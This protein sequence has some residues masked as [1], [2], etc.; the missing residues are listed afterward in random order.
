MAKD[1]VTI[2]S[3]TEY[4]IDPEAE[5]DHIHTKKH[6]LARESAVPVEDPSHVMVYEKRANSVDLEP[7]SRFATNIVMNT[8]LTDVANFGWWARDLE[9]PQRHQLSLSLTGLRF[10][11]EHHKTGF[12]EYSQEHAAYCWEA[13]PGT[14]V[15]SAG[16]VNK[17]IA[18]SFDIRPGDLVFVMGCADDSAVEKHLND[19]KHIDLGYRL[20][21]AGIKLTPT[22]S[23]TY[24]TNGTGYYFVPPT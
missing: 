4:S 11:D 22:F 24:T 7:S 5:T 3:V 20:Y 17:C 13:E 6:R 1:S 12:L 19:P 14:L 21:D 2:T 15:Y 18:G 16:I 10:P 8:E 9:I 23:R